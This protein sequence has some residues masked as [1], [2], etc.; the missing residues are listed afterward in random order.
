MEEL[1]C[2]NATL[3]ELEYTIN[4]YESDCETLWMECVRN[5]LESSDCVT[6]DFMSSMS[7]KKFIDFMKEQK[8][9]K[10]MI[11]SYNRLKTRKELLEDKLRPDT[12]EGL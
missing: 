11:I 10:F 3:R 5:F 7:N 1:D 12:D 6:C 2:V 9:Y 4:K 8:M